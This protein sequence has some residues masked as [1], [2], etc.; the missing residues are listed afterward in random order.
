MRGVERLE[1]DI[2]IGHRR[3]VIAAGIANRPG[4]G[5]STARTDLEESAG[6]DV[7]DGSAAG[8]DRVNI[9]HR[10]LDRIA[11]HDR[12]A[13]EPRH[14]AFQQCDIGAGAAHVEGDEVFE[15]RHGSHRLGP[16][17]AGA[18]PGEHGAHRQAGGR[19]EADHPAI[20]LRE[21]RRGG[22]AELGKAPGEPGRARCSCSGR[23]NP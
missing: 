12:F 23:T 13:R 9:Q 16:D 22:D 8:A 19:V 21:L 11:M 20:R 15:G 6:I 1:D 17:H 18:G 3:L 10:R 4:I 14:A 5:A 7:S 2:G